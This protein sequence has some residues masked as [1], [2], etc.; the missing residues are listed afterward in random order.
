MLNLLL[1]RYHRTLLRTASYSTRNTK[2][3]PKSSRSWLLLAAGITATGGLVTYSIWPHRSSS[4]ESRLAPSYFIHATV[5]SSQETSSN[6]KLLTLGIPPELVPAQEED[7]LSSIWSIFIKDDE[8]QVERPYTPLEGIDSLGRMNFWIK[9]YPSGEVGRW[10][11]SK[12]VGDTV[13]IRGPLSTWKWVDDSW[14]DVI[15][16]RPYSV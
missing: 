8:I 14:D 13:E 4:S 11:H 2:L 6:T 7:S 15:M 16:V 1:P 5:V 12:N 3:L 10:L 9:R